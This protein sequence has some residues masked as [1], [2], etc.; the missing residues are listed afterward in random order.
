MA[1]PSEISVV[2][3]SSDSAAYDLWLAESQVEKTAYLSRC[4]ITVVGNQSTLPV[5]DEQTIFEGTGCPD[6]G[7]GT[8]YSR[9]AP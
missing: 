3:L 4:L 5:S 6:S 1:K 7:R 9:Q 2:I 8:M